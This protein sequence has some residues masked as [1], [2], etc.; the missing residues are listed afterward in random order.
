MGELIEFIAGGTIA[1][2]LAAQW[3]RRHRVQVSQ[4]L[5]E[6]HRP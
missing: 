3:L 5:R 4:W 2:I 6:Q 1:A